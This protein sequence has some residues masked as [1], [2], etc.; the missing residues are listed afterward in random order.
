MS[1]DELIARTRE[2]GARAVLM[3]SISRG[4]PHELRIVSAAGGEMLSALIESMQLRREVQ[5]SKAIRITGLLEITIS[6]S[7][8]DQAREIAETMSS[9]LDVP[10]KATGSII[11]LGEQGI[12]RAIMRLTDLPQGRL[13]WTY[14]HADDG[15]E[16][17]P[18]VR[19]FSVRR[20]IPNES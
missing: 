19:I 16:I 1:L 4:N 15:I 20:N 13:I 18:R 3:V 12:H 6:E 8:S 9:L 11:P 10:L 2:S 7:A 14:H 5:P 17:G